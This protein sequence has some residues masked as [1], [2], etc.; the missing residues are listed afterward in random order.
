MLQ[1]VIDRL[2]H[3]VG[4]LRLVEGA[5]EFASANETGAPQSPAAYVVP[6]DETTGPSRLVGATGQTLTTRYGVLLAFRHVGD[7]RGESASKALETV[8][9]AVREALLGWAPSTGHSPSEFAGSR[10]IS[11]AD[12]VV[13]RRLDFST[14]SEIRNTG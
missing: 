4:D 6:L 11:V 14:E 5:A 7:A 12:G 8:G 2:K 10:L 13:W 1:E 3:R 9:E